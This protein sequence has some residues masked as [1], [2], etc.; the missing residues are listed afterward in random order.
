[1]AKHHIMDAT[2]HSTVEFDKANTVDLDAAM[3]RFAALTGA[4]HVAATRTAGDT[5]YTVIKNPADEQDETL[6]VPQMRGG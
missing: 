3:K 6:F 2:G 1:M 4:G 5:D